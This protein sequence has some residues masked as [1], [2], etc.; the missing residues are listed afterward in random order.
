MTQFYELIFRLHTHNV[1]ER[2]VYY[3]QQNYKINLEENILNRPPQNKRNSFHFK[4]KKKEM[5]F[6]EIETY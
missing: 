1:T 5:L 6:L 3:T 2:C 4:V